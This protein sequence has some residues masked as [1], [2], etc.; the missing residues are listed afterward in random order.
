MVPLIPEL[1]DYDNTQLLVIG[2]PFQPL[3][4]LSEY[5]KENWETPTEGSKDEKELR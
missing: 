5:Q 2:E 1:L 3:E 4:G